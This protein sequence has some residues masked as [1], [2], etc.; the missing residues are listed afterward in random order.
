MAGICNKLFKLTIST[1][2]CCLETTYKISLQVRNRQ[3]NVPRLR[4]PLWYLKKE[5]TLYPEKLTLENK[6]FIEEV[7][8]DTFGPPAVL[9]GIST[10]KTTSPL[11]TQPVEKG[12]WTENSKRCGL[13]T[14]KIGCYPMWDKN[15]KII[16]S[17]LLQVIDNHVVKYTPPEEVDP[18]RKPKRFLKPNKYGV[19]LVGAESANP[20]LY[21]KE[22]CGLFTAA[23]LPPKKFLGKFNITPDAIIQ[24]GT[25]LTACHYQPGDIVDVC[26]KTVDR[27]FQGVM[28][29]WGFKGMPASHGV[30]KTHRRGG[31][32]GGGGEKGRVWPGT[33]MP[34]HMG[35]KWRVLRGLK[36]WRINTKYNILYVQGLGV[37]GETNSLIYVHD[38]LLPLRK[39]KESPLYFPTFYPQLVDTP[40]PD[41]LYDSTVHPFDQPSITFAE[42]K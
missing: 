7:V 36:I 34:G 18:P 21:T 33:K 28:K 30:T 12:V 29:R 8:H 10:Y 35:N 24:P 6:E 5:R 22:Y 42:S 20:Q 23:G 9:S 37:P 40:L 13:I 17:T 11:K 14:R 3:K 1:N 15:G 25:P 26:G 38:T 31:N 32:I 41:D 39:R 27:G 4:F 16:W 19:L 2:F